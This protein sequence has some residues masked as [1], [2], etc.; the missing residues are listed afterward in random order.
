M[1][2]KRENKLS[3]SLVHMYSYSCSH[4]GKEEERGRGEAKGERVNNQ[5]REV[6]KEGRKRE[7][8]EGEKRK[9]QKEGGLNFVWYCSHSVCQSLLAQFASL[10]EWV[11]AVVLHAHNP[12]TTQT[13]PQ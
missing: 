9:E 12:P 8:R 4:S 2:G 3:I 6:G 10:L 11:G 1:E 7:E 5:E 13:P